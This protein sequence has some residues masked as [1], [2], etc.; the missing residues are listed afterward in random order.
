MLF[1]LYPGCRTYQAGLASGDDSCAVVLLA[2][3]ILF[4][5]N[6]SIF[7]TTWQTEAYVYSMISGY[8]NGAAFMVQLLRGHVNVDLLSLFATLHF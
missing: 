5:S 7:S 6:P 2:Q 1:M 3:M 4:D 8:L